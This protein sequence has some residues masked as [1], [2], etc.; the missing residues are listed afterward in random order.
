M[1]ISVLS[2]QRIIHVFRRINVFLSCMYMY[3]YFGKYCLFLRDAIIRYTAEKGTVAP[4]CLFRS[5]NQH[6]CN[7]LHLLTIPCYYGR[8]ALVGQAG[9]E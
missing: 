6:S 7:L 3:V 4:S 9:R 8:L 5:D 1:K 2:S